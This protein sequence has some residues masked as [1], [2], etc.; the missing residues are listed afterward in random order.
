MFTIVIDIF[1]SDEQ[2]KIRANGGSPL[3]YSSDV[4]G[5]GKILST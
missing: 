2:A 1:A 4:S 5:V 3:L